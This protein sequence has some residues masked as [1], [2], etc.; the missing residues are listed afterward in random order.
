M[1]LGKLIKSVL[2][3][4]GLLIKDLCRMANIKQAYASRLI[5]DDLNPSPDILKAISQALDIKYEVLLVA[6]GILE[7][8][9]LRHIIVPDTLKSFLAEAINLNPANDKNLKLI[10][11]YMNEKQQFLE[12]K[13]DFDTLMSTILNL[14]DDLILPVDYSEIDYSDQRKIEINDNN[15]DYL[16]IKNAL[17]ISSKDDNR[18]IELP[19]IYDFDNNNTPIDSGLKYQID[20][21]SVAA[22]RHNNKYWFSPQT[23]L[24]HLY[25][26][27]TDIKPTDFSI[28][29]FKH[30][31]LI[32]FGQ[33]RSK[34]LGKS[35]IVTIDICD[36]FNDINELNYCPTLYNEEIKRNYVEFCKGNDQELKDNIQSLK[37][38]LQGIDNKNINLILESLYKDFEKKCSYIQFDNSNPPNDLKILGTIVTA[39]SNFT[40]K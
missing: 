31:P 32:S 39:V 40:F 12:D 14:K 36:F 16:R 28:V 35:S 9:S 11:D 5:K 29:L 22:F 15:L 18:P 4:K 25:L 30:G 3:K 34:T 17:Y 8:N 2:E 21:M 24:R 7:S 23:N 1:S 6:A 13:M 38:Q 33:Y 10:F 27:I 19:V 26:V 37:E 20:P